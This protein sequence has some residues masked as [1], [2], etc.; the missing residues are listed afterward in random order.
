MAIEGAALI[1]GVLL[2]YLVGRDGKV[3]EVAVVAPRR[4]DGRQLSVE[5]LGLVRIGGPAFPTAALIPKIETMALEAID[6]SLAKNMQPYAASTAYYCEK[7]VDARLAVRILLVL[8]STCNAALTVQVV[9]HDFNSP[10]DV[11]GLVNIGSGQSLAANS[12]L[13]LGIDLSTD[14]Y[15]FLGVTVTSSGVPPT[16]GSVVVAAYGQR[17]VQKAMI[18]GRP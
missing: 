2:G 1:T 10:R 12:K 6:E 17:W 9:G 13:G 8:L 16:S 3:S 4:R 11:N 5:E 7:L 14:W 18:G 15:P